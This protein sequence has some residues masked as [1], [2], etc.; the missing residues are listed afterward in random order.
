MRFEEPQRE[1]R[2]GSLAVGRPVIDDSADRQIGEQVGIAGGVPCGGAAGGEHPVAWRSANRIAGNAELA[3]GGAQDAQI[4]VAQSLDPMGANQ[5]TSHLHDFHQAL[6][7][8]AVAAAD[9][10]ATLLAKALAASGSQWS[11][12]PTMVRSLG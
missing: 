1:E 3:L 8:F 4:H 7:P 10:G 11:M 2:G 9:T 6:P 12:M 5:G